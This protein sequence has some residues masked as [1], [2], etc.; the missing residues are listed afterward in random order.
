M[1]TT[2]GQGFVLSGKSVNTTSGGSIISLIKLRNQLTFTVSDIEANVTIPGNNLEGIS[3]FPLQ[4]GGYLVIGNE[5][6]GTP[7]RSICLLKVNNDLTLSWTSPSHL[8]FGGINDDFAGNVA[9]LPDGRLLIF[10]TMS[11]GN[12][13]QKK[14]ALIKLNKDGKFLD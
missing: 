2:S 8:L 14:M 11:L 4:S 6:A 12:E 3:A 7:N 1:S 13:G 10:G 5:G 9:E